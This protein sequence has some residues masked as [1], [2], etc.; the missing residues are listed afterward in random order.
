MREIIIALIILRSMRAYIINN[1]LY[2]CGMFIMDAGELVF[3]YHS[4]LSFRKLDTRE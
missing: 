1:A 3:Q 2:E 4:S